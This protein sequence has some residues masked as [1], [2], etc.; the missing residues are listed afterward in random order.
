MPTVCH[1]RFGKTNLIHLQP[2]SAHPRHTRV[3][4]DHDAYSPEMCQNGYYNFKNH[5][6]SP[7]EETVEGKKIIS[8]K[9]SEWQSASQKCPRNVQ[10]GLARPPHLPGRYGTD[11]IKCRGLRSLS[12]LPVATATARL[13]DPCT[14]RHRDGPPPTTGPSQHPGAVGGPS[15]AD[16]PCSGKGLGPIK[17]VRR[18]D[19][20]QTRSCWTLPVRGCVTSSRRWNDVATVCGLQT[21]I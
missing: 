13:G 21:P 15:G 18:A 7:R 5:P 12:L 19:A 20:G 17:Q 1:S 11:H 3:A 8:K 10:T 16:G 2:P 4:R 9:I 14:C 6:T